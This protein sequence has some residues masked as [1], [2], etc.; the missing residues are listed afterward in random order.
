MFSKAEEVEMHITQHHLCHE[1]FSTVVWL[2]NLT[3][4]ENTRTVYM[5]FS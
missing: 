5:F 3:Y 4:L 2:N 1:V